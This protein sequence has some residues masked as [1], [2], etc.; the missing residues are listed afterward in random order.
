MMWN[1]LQKQILGMQWLNELIG[2]LL[3]SVGVDI[4]GRGGGSLQFFLYDVIKIT[5]LL[6]VLIFIIS[7]IQSYFPPER[8]K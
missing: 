2:S 8:S 4:S 1:F 3:T 7:Y 6:C 5:I